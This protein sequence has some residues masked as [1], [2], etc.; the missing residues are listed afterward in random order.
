VAAWYDTRDGN[1]EIY[2]RVLHGD[3][4][5]AGPERRLTSS[6]EQSYEVSIDAVGSDLAVAW[7]DKAPDGALV[8]KLGVWE[9]GGAWRWSRE[10]G[11]G[12]RNPV[13][14]AQGARVF[15][16]W[17]A[18]DGDGSE[19]VLAGWWSATGEPA[20][21]PHTIGAAGTTTWNLNAAVDADGTGWVVFDAAAGTKSEELFVGRV[22]ARGASIARVSADDGFASK[23]PDLAIEDRR[24]ALTWYDQRDGNAE[25]YLAVGSIADL[26]MAVD[27]RARRVTSTVGESIGAYVAWNRGRIGLAWSDDTTGQ[28]EVYFRTFDARGD[29]VRDPLRITKTAASSLIPAIRPWGAGF[30]LAWNE[31]TPAGAGNEAHSGSRSHIAAVTM[32]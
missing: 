14:R 15:A 18:R 9:S 5:P 20:G 4:A 29:P 7:Y 1:G 27:V 10:M 16:A 32:P 28:H 6:S 17:I 11:E 26:T 21:G 13:V 30:A 12:T 3:G 2:I 22:D 8:S 25:V 23:Y 24:T 31:Y 19:S